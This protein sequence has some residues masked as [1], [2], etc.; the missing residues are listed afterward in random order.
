MRRAEEGRVKRRKGSPSEREHCY[1]VPICGLYFYVGIAD[2]SVLAYNAPCIFI[3]L[4]HG[5]FDVVNADQ[6]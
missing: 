3:S 1:R 4:V 5:E 2:R 6:P